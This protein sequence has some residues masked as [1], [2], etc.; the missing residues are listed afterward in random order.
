MSSKPAFS[1]L[2]LVLAAP[3]SATAIDTVNP[4]ASDAARQVLSYF[5][6]LP[7]RCDRRIVSGQHFGRSAVSFQDYVAGLRQATGEW[8]GLI[9]ADYGHPRQ[10]AA[11]SAGA[12]LNALNRVLIGYWRAGGWSRSA[13]T[14]GTRGRVGTPGIRNRGIWMS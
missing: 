1:I 12:D 3:F 5:A 7:K 10:D 2:T 14:R 8:V 6:E 9:G 11:N 13:T 4:D